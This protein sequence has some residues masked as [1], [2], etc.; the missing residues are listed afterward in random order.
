MDSVIFNGKQYVMI[1]YQDDLLVTKESDSLDYVSKTLYGH[2]KIQIKTISKTETDNFEQLI[3]Y[4]RGKN[5]LQ[6]EVKTLDCIETI[7]SNNFY[8]KEYPI[9]ING[10]S[11]FSFGEDVM[12]S[13][14]YKMEPP[15]NTI[16]FLLEDE[17]NTR[18][19]Y[20]YYNTRNKRFIELGSFALYKDENESKNGVKF[21]PLTKIA[22]RFR[23]FIL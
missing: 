4:V 19:C 17:N 3:R 22:T 8:N 23:D 5:I 20:E 12:V 14:C 10:M 13:Y 2:I 15:K 16:F 21:F 7:Y 11:C 1:Y 18:I 9:F 6:Q